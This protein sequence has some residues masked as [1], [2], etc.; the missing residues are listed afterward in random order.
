[1]FN[2]VYNPFQEQVFEQISEELSRGIPTTVDEL[3]STS[4]KWMRS[5]PN[6]FIQLIEL[7]FQ[8]NIVNLTDERLN[9]IN[10]ACI[11]H[12]VFRKVNL[13]CD[14]SIDGINGSIK[15]HSTVLRIFSEHYRMVMNAGLAER[16]KGDDGLYHLSMRDCSLE[17]LNLF[18][19]Y[20]YKET[21]PTISAPLKEAH[22]ISSYLEL[23]SLA[24]M[25]EL[26]NLSNS[27][28]EI[29]SDFEKKIKSPY[30][31]EQLFPFYHYIIEE[32]NEGVCV[33][34]KQKEFLATILRQMV[35]YS[36]SAFNVA[37]FD[38]DFN[39]NT[40]FMHLKDIR[41][42]FE[43]KPSDTPDIAT[44]REIWRRHIEG[45]YISSAKDLPILMSAR[46]LNAE[47]REQV[48]AISFRP[49]NLL[50]L[51]S[52][53]ALDLKTTFPNLLDE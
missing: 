46:F 44:C 6:S 13:P 5:Y 19:K 33:F 25:W 16:D 15:I 36:I 2:S 27:I 48:R 29:F 12:Y 1:M 35:S 31:V 51:D 41:V 53:E 43:D 8:S 34:T 42:L 14:L 3:L 11:L 28:A 21:L 47:L 10:K 23:D 40:M 37:K 39:R 49:E 24:E 20:I 38:W 9:Q 18:K 45:V 17:C 7:V 26:P 52:I 32:E 50:S 30:K 22:S 4:K